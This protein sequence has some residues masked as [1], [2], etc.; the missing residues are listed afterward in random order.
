MPILM[1]TAAAF[2]Y[3]AGLLV[4][5]ASQRAGGPAPR[6]W[7]TW[8]TWADGGPPWPKKGSWLF[9]G[10]PSLLPLWGLASS[11]VGGHLLPHPGMFSS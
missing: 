9:P 5:G 8:L 1:T 4:R 11:K 6:G 2:T 7:E 10:P 3:I